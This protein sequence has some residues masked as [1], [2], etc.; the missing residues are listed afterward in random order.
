MPSDP[1]RPSNWDDIERWLKEGQAVRI[2]IVD[3][4][5]PIR[6]L[7]GTVLEPEGY[8]MDFCATG[9]EGLEKVKEQEYDVLI[10]DKN[11]PGMTG[12]DLLREAQKLQPRLASIV[13]TA[14]MSYE[15]VP[16]LIDR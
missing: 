6:K 12:L 11:L 15:S 8:Q 3:D 14:Y 4:E 5:E 10:V 9:E 16:N 1:P 7:L 13:I 2:L